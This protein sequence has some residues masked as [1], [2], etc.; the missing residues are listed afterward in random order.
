MKFLKNPYIWLVAI[1]LLAFAVRL[2]KIDNPVADWHSWRQADT[3]SVTRIYVEQGIDILH[4]RYQD[5]SFLQSGK[6]NPEGWR[7][8]E[9]PIYNAIHALLVNT[10]PFFSLEKWG[11]LLSVFCSL[12]S[13]A[14]LFLLGRRFIG[15]TGGLLTAGA[16]AM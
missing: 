13:T 2:Y 9:F 8:V 6:Y 11:R 14:V 5:I 3:S 4:P 7:F 16:F 10:L 12:I 15:T 1:L